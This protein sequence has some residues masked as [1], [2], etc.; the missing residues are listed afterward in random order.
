MHRRGFLKA[1]VYAPLAIPVAMVSSKLGSFSNKAVTLKS[2]VEQLTRNLSQRAS[3]LNL[4]K[5]VDSIE[6]KGDVAI[7]RWT[8]R[9]VTAPPPPISPNIQ[10]PTVSRISVWTYT[11]VFNNSSKAI[12]MFGEIISP[13]VWT[14][15]SSLVKG[16]SL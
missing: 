13:G 14:S 2:A 4:T 7:L 15:I 8:E 1:A 12:H 16:V 6:Y 10:E 5:W 9:Y 3:D 11:Y